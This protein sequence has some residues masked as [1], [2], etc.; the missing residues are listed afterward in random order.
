M[1]SISL[2]LNRLPWPTDWAAVF[3]RTAPLVIEVG[4]G[5][6]QFLLRYARSRPQMNFLGL[7]IAAPSLRSTENRI[8]AAGLTNVRL[9]RARVQSALQALCEPDEIQGVIVNFPDPWPKAAHHRRRLIS[10]SFLELLAS[11]MAAGADLDIATDHVD[12]GLWIAE[13]LQAS[14]H[15]DSRITTPYVHEDRDRTRTKYEQKGL[16]AGSQCFYFKWRR[17]FQPSPD[18]HP[19]VQEWPMPHVVV[20]SPLALDD[21]AQQFEP[22]DCALDGGSIKLL[23][24]FGSRTRPSLIVDTYIVEKPVEQR[25]MLEIYRRPDEDYVIRLFRTGFPRSTGGVHKAIDCLSRWF[26]GLHPDTVLIRHN[27]RS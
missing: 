15:F 4:F 6:G 27:L 21:I 12:Y 14:P 13:R 20:R 18:N 5:N 8:R 19:V 10:D 2:E 26:C 22:Q 24:I 1:D 25:V 23:D 16:A 11:R 3:A 17:N 7:E 9:M